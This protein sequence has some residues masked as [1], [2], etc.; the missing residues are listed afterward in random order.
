MEEQ[1][2][3]ITPET[4]AALNGLTKR[5]DTRLGEVQA[6]VQSVRAEVD[7]LQAR[8]DKRKSRLLFVFNMVALL[9][10]LM[11]GWIVYTQVVVIRHQWARVRR[12]AA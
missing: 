2:T 9:S 6:N 7:A 11:L 8:L 1:K 5:I 10:T 4:V 12:P 3:G